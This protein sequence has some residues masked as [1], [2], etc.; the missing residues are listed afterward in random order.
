[1]TIYF[2]FNIMDVC[3]PLIQNLLE[4]SSPLLLCQVQRD[5][6]SLAYYSY[7]ASTLF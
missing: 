1:M 2:L 7:Q 4:D 3:I 5:L 6:A